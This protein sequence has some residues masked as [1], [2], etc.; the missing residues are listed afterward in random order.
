MQC[1]HIVRESEQIVDSGKTLFQFIFGNVNNK[2]LTQL[3]VKKCHAI[4]S[5]DKKTIKPQTLPPIEEA[6]EQHTLK[7]PMEYR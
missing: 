3:R 7:A 6:A 4:A 1:R 5:D 2:S